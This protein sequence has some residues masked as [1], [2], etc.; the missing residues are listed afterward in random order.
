MEANLSRNEG[1]PDTPLSGRM[2]A[3]YEVEIMDMPQVYVLFATDA[4]GQT[5]YEH[6]QANPQFLRGSGPKEPSTQ[7]TRR[8]SVAGSQTS[9][10]TCDVWQDVCNTP[11]L[12]A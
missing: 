8:G 1:H 6:V 9:T 4:Q 2:L 3:L 12:Q 10:C 7:K 5:L 11:K